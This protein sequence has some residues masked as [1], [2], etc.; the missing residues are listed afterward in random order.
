ADAQ[1]Q[2]GDDFLDT[3]AHTPTA[4]IFPSGQE[5]ILNEPRLAALPIVRA[6]QV[7]RTTIPQFDVTR[8]VLFIHSLRG[9]L[10]DPASYSAINC[11]LVGESDSIRVYAEQTVPDGAPLDSLI[12]ELTQLADETIGPTVQ[13]LVGPVRDVDGDGKLA[14]VLTS[15]LGPADGALTNVDGLTRANDFRHQVLRP[16][17]NESDVIFLNANL[18]P[19]ERL[20][21]VF[22]HEWAHAAIFSRRYGGSGGD[23][24]PVPTEDDWLNEALAHLIEVRAS[25][26]SSNVAHRIQSFLDRPEAAPLVVRDYYRP[27]Y[28]RHH[29]CR[30]AAFLFLEWCL[31]QSEPLRIDRLI[32]G[33]SVGVEHLEQATQQSFENLFRGWTTS[34]GRELAASEI[35]GDETD[36]GEKAFHQP[37]LSRPRPQ[38]WKPN[39]FPSQCKTLRLRGTTAT[40]VR[41]ALDDAASHWRLV[42]DAPSECR[43]QLTVIPVA[44]AR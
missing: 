22:A 35:A 34:L 26:S 40:Y 37:A 39:Q 43:L 24:E 17:G 1:Q 18:S 30:G 8:R 23:L 27:E 33:P 6:N 36:S 14:V 31:N 5:Q 7:A 16:I 41:I 9:S 42:A 15:Q 2:F 28:W 25:G 21:A 38:E 12:A 19:G 13:A 32:D 20:R 29:G 4:D 10:T 11:R 44:R 3:A